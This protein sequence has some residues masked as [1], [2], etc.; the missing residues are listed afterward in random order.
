[1]NWGCSEILDKQVLICGPSQ[2][3]VQELALS[4]V[5]EGY[6]I[7]TAVNL[8]QAVKRITSS[9][10]RVVVLML[11]TTDQTW[12][13]LIQLLNRLLPTLPVIVVADGNS[14]ITER[15]ARQ[16]TIFYYLLRPVDLPEMMAVLRL[17]M[18]KASR[19]L[20]N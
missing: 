15:Q 7:Q 1:M 10:F 2:P 5:K 11:K 19:P 9:D 12:L 18:K 14:L 17:A 4:L 13:E 8:F 6:L 20:F 3:E 16:G